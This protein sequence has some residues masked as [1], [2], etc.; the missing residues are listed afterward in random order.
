[1]RKNKV[2]A[3]IMVVVLGVSLAGCATPSGYYD[4]ARSTA[5]GAGGGALVGAALGAI[6][7][8]AAGDAA[9]GAWVGAA[10]GAI[11]GGVG[12]LLYARHQN[13]QMRNREM[14]M[15]QYGYTPERGALVDVNDARV[16]PNTVRPGQTVDVFMTYTVLTPDGT[17]TQ[18]TLQREI[19]QN[20]RPVGQPFAVQAVNQNG[21]YEDRVAF[22]VPRDAGPGPY[23][24]TNR[25]VSNYGSAERTAFFT[26]VQ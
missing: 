6:I 15:A 23:T 7:G 5:A 24:V 13:Q 10:T 19:R 3:L 4:P 2:L 20:G 12:G 8:A 14:A 26:V 11:A 25:V 1:M 16:M 22:T 17:P 9:T 18:V 21:T